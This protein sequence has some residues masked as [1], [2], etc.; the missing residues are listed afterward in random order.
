ML[1]SKYVSLNGTEDLAL[2][3]FCKTIV[4]RVSVAP[5]EIEAPCLSA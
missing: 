1:S 4:P 5:V 3:V 2:Q